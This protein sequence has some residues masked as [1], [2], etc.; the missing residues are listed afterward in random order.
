LAIGIIG[1]LPWIG[2]AVGMYANARHSDRT[3]ERYW[4]VALPA[5]CAAALLL[6]AWQLGPGPAALVALLLAGLG[7]GSAQGGFWAIPTPLLKP[8]EFSVAVVGINILGSAGGFVMPQLMGLARER[9]GGF[10][11]PTLLVVAV[12]AMATLLVG[13]IRWIYRRE[14]AASESACKPGHSSA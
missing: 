5:L 8:R 4:H 11:V 7:L 13:A 9:S 6:A 2:V 12:L 3:G 14:T 1:A 10:A